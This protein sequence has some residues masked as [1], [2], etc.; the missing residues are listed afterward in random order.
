LLNLRTPTEEK[1]RRRA[2]IPLAEYL[3]GDFFFC[4]L[5]K[6]TSVLQIMSS[7]ASWQARLER[8]RI[9]LKKMDMT[10]RFVCKS[11]DSFV[12]VCNRLQG[13]SASPSRKCTQQA[14]KRRLVV[15]QQEACGNTQN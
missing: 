4:L 15:E 2:R 1:V 6:V 9:A 3:K 13:P 7:D 12:E 14:S 8:R 5:Q 10:V 11:H